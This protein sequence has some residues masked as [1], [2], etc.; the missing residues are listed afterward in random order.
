MSIRSIPLVAALVLLLP[1]TAPAQGRGWEEAWSLELSRGASATPVWVDSLLLVAGLD[2]NLQLVSVRPEPRV[3]WK[4]N[5]KGGFDAAPVVEGDRIYL[6]QAGLRSKGLVAIDRR[7]RKTEWSA[8]AGDLEARPVVS[9]GSI[10]TVSSTG[11]VSAWG[12]NGTR[13]WRT[14]LDD[15]VVA[16]PA[17]LG[18][19]L[20]VATSGGTLYALD[21]RS[22]KTLRSVDPDAGPV[23]GDLVPAPGASDAVLLATLNGQLLEVHADLSIPQR[24]SFPGRFAT[25]P[26]VDGSR[27][28]LAGHDG[29][30][31]AYDWATSEVLW[32]R[33][34]TGVFRAAPGLVDGRVAVGNLA[35]TLYLLN[36]ADGAL[37][38]HTRLEGAIGASPLARGDRLYVVTEQGRLH[39]FRPTGETS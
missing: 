34:L 23:W 18:G 1:A 13:L 17:L 6:P 5:Y 37:E 22:G 21:A 28:Y 24:R 27:I 33:T 16:T 8:D 38:W 2:R 36:A 32:K 4:D 25:G 20:V 9:G 15:R 26:V 31:W 10:Y 12:R 14:E 29:T 39:A 35:G 30:I 3:V 19:T 7:T 11:V